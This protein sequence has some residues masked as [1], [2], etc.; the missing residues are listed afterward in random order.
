MA[1]LPQ[2]FTGKTVDEAVAEGL[3]KLG[4]SRSKVTVE[5]L[6]RGSRGIFGIGSE[7]ARVRL[8]MAESPS[9]AAKPQASATARPAPAPSREPVAQ[10]DIAQPAAADDE[11]AEE[12]WEEEWEEEDEGD[13]FAPEPAAR[14]AASAP[15][16]TQAETQAAPVSD[17]EL[18]DMAA[19]L[20]SE[21]VRLMGFQAT[22]A[23]AWQEPDEHEGDPYLRLDIEGQDL[24][25]LIGRRGET[26]AA[27][28][29]LIRLMVNQRV[30]QWKNIVVDVESYK[31]RRITQLTQL[32]QRMAD[33][34]AE[35]GR[36][37]ALEPMPAN[38]RRI[39]HLTL[40]DHPRVYTQ[41][42][43]EEERRKVNIVP[44][45]AD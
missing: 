2:E 26:L 4:L 33:Q 12:E 31:E 34:V 18:A 40:R 10:P 22:V 8:T 9:S 24:G 15:Q 36:A 21:M 29:Y 7:P 30:R 44:R 25:S 35:S 14:G 41:S 28:Q 32:A 3:A 27:I 11:E 6:S 45:D 5:I 1:A 38:E 17:E 20:L 42:S 43:G 13:V 37:V 39:V 19:G 23:A 16:A